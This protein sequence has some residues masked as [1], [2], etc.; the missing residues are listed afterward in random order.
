MDKVELPIT[1]MH[2]AA[3]AK[4]IEEKLSATPGVQQAAVN[5]A[6]SRATVAYDPEATGIRAL[7]NA[8]Q[9]AGYG[10]AGV[11]QVLFV[12]DDSARPS[13]S[14]SPLERELEKLPG[15]ASASFNLSA[16]EVRVEY[17]LGK[18]DVQS[19]R[20]AIEQFG[21]HVQELPDEARED[22][23][24]SARKA[25]YRELLR[26]F[27]VAAA[28]SLPVLVIA[29]SHSRISLLDFPGV[30]WL[31]LALTTPV[32]FYSGRQFY[33]GAWLAFK[34]RLADMNTLIAVG[35]GTAYVYSVAATV[36]PGFF[37]T[38]SG[39]RGMSDMS[40][41]PPVYFEAASVIIALILLG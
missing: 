37:A 1:G 11:A 19:I 34:H 18:T 4:H 15:V 5:F 39:H 38:D 2:C 21:Y 8:V 41:A 7:M 24:D 17:L 9:D 35:T 13:G 26:K 28:F 25:E 36:A 27:W 14:A 12:V 3:C 10:T 31:Q 20:R 16:M 29:M 6:T 30:N 33:R 32:V 22:W 40:A 23:E